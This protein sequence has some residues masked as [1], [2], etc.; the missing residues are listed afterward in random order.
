MDFNIRNYAV[1]DIFGIELWITESLR[2]TWIIMAALILFAIIVRIALI[3]FKAVPKGFQNVVEAL[4]ETFDN[5]VEG[6]AGEKFLFLGNWFFMA[7]AFI[8]ISNISGM[9]FLRPPTADWT[10][11]FAL[12]VATFILIHGVALK[13]RGRRY[14]KSLFEPNPVF[15]IL[16]VIGEVARPIALSFRLFGNVL[17]GTILLT[18]MYT[19][20]PVF[21]RFGI[22]AALHVFFDLFMG[23]LQTYIFCILSISFISIAATETEEA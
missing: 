16:N 17:A 13:L 3:R 22:P 5:F 19:T 23:A 4:V 10:V 6:A 9:F 1:L 2:N 18:L 15:F 12:A 21:L 14:I 11:T 7:F 8:F 20:A